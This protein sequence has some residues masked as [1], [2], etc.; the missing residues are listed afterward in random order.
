MLNIHYTNIGFFIGA[1]QMCDTLPPSMPDVTLYTF[2]TVALDQDVVYRLVP[3]ASG[4]YYIDLLNLG[5]GTLYIRADGDPAPDDPQSETL[6]AMQYDN[7][8]PVD[9]VKGLRIL[10]DQAGQVTARMVSR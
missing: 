4:T 8:I 2:N 10:S 6:P 7:E 1:S 9:G 3:R 5:P